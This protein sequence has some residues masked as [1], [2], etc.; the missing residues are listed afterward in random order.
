[1]QSEYL[2]Q[3]GHEA[4]GI[5]RN[6]D[7]D[8]PL[9]AAVS[10]ANN[11]RMVRLLVQHFERIIRWKNKDEVDALMLAARHGQD[12]AVT[13]LLTMPGPNSP[14][15]ADPH[16][17]DS[18]GDTALHYASAYGQLK[19]V[20]T[21]IAHGADPWA[22]NKFHWTPIDYSST[23]AVETYLRNLVAG[24]ERQRVV[25]ARMRGDSGGSTGGG[26][27]EAGLLGRGGVRLVPAA[28]DLSPGG[29]AG[30]VSGVS[31]PGPTPGSDIEGAGGD[32]RTSPSPG[33][34]AR[35]AAGNGGRLGTPTRE[36]DG[37]FGTP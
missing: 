9:M 29:G 32:W 28:H 18:K 36:R 1:M 11:E 35:A 31:T 23:K 4:Q 5:S 19:V 27:G 16:E 17:R 10:K 2:I 15:A 6:A 25:G 3:A 8:T 34:R 22:G 37:Y 20:H 7:W 26:G 33:R 13:L 24:M 12:G 14:Y 30:N 21:L